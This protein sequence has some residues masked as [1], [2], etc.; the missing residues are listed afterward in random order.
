MHHSLTQ[1]YI[2]FNHLLCHKQIRATP[3]VWFESS[4]EHGVI[5]KLASLQ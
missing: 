1:L 5:K 4:I 2:D 3:I